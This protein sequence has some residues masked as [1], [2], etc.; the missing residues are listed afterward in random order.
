VFQVGTSVL[1][2]EHPSPTP[3]QLAAAVSRRIDSAGMSLREVA[4]GANIPLSTFSR[5][6]NGSPFLSTE[7]AALGSV[8][9]VTVSQLVAEAETIPPTTDS[10]AA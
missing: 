3:A 9:G 2:M 4:R 10:G 7:L 8:F 6:L 5:R 1:H